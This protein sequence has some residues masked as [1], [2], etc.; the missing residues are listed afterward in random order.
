LDLNGVVTSWN[1]GA[2]RLFG[3]TASEMVGASL[4]RLSPPECQREEDQVFTRIQNE[5]VEPM[6]VVRVRKDGILIDVSI[7]VSPIKDAAGNVVGTSKVARDITARKQAEITLHEAK[8]D[9]EAKVVLRTSELL[10][11]KESAEAANCAKSQFLANMSHE[12]RTPM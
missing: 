1:I 7:T 5:R 4:T 6:E 3:Y 8:T 10:E 11:A 2:E 9:L 12:I